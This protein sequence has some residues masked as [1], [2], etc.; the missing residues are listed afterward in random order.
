MVNRARHQQQRVKWSGGNGRP[1]HTPDF[2]VW[3]AAAHE[4]QIAIIS[5]RAR[6]WAPEAL[7]A[8]V[9]GTMQADQTIATDLAGINALIREARSRGL[10]TEYVGPGRPVVL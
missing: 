1:E 8:L 10:V 9:D 6:A 5:Q 4:W 3:C 7:A 2:R